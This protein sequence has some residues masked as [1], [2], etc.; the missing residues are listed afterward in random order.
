M[1]AV[2]Q[3][4]KNKKNIF[5]E[6]LK[7]LGQKIKNFKLPNAFYY[8]LLLVAISIGF[9]LVMLGQNGFT[10]AFGGDY[11]A[12]YIPMGYHIWDYYHDCVFY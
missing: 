7:V 8:F 2:F 12:Q 9:Y 6:K 11:S 10:I 5:A 1:N 4:D 3:K